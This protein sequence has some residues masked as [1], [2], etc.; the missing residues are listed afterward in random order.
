MSRRNPEMECARPG[1]VQGEALLIAQT[2]VLRSGDNYSC[3]TLG[4]TLPSGRLI[5]ARFLIYCQSDSFRRRFNWFI[6][7]ILWGCRVVSSFCY[8]FAAVNSLAKS[9]AS[10]KARQVKNEINHGYVFFAKSILCLFFQKTHECYAGMYAY[11]TL[12]KWFFS[13]SCTLCPHS[14]LRYHWH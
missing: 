4:F 8:E 7:F 6:M 3:L 14:V 9:G 2:P 13:V 5:L 12:S 1:S 11:I 10:A